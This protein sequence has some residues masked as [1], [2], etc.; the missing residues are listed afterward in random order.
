MSNYEKYKI[1]KDKCLK[2]WLLNKKRR[3]DKCEKDYAYMS[4]DRHLKSKKHINKCLS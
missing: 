2:E 3:C 1:T 4:Y